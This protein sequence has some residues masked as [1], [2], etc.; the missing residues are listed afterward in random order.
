MIFL[1]S[2]LSATTLIGLFCRFKLVL[3]WSTWGKIET[4]DHIR[5]LKYVQ[6]FENN[7]SKINKPSITKTKI[8]PYTK[9]CFKPDY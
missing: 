9:V 2:I 7:L 4:V 6:T 8:K 1:T 3:I 5:G